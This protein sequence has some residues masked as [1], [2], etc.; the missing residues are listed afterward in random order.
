MDRSKS[1]SNLIT[2]K[3]ISVCQSCKENFNSNTNLPYLLKCG[4]FFCRFCLEHKFNEE[5]GRIFCPDD[6]IVANSIDDLKVLN[7]LV[8]EKNVDDEND[9]SNRSSVSSNIKILLGIL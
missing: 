3:Y 6:G 4:H 7:N 9:Q 1:Y 5:D 2:L 8:I